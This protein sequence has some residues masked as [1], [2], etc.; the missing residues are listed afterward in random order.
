MKS[1]SGEIR[2]DF[3]AIGAADTSDNDKLDLLAKH[4]GYALSDIEQALAL[5]VIGKLNSRTYNAYTVA[6]SLGAVPGL[7]AF[8]AAIEAGFTFKDKHTER[9]GQLYALIAQT[10]TGEVIAEFGFTEKS[11]DAVA[12]T[13][14]EPKF[15]K[16]DT[17]LGRFLCDV[18]SQGTAC[19]L[20]PLESHFGDLDR[21]G[22]VKDEWKLVGL[23][24]GVGFPQRSYVLGL[25]RAIQTRDWP[26]KET[27]VQ[28]G[29]KIR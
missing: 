28:L 15:A 29:L 16:R 26:D 8:A 13:L 9:W 5:D 7:G 20:W 3:K 10:A 12:Q 14:R 11:I 21:I 6:S 18:E 24:C 23:E 1:Y 19:Y 25:G 4:A 27:L 22:F 17:R 2:R